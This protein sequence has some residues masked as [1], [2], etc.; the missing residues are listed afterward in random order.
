MA[1]E[2]VT[3]DYATSAGTPDFAMRCNC[4]SSSCRKVITGQDWRRTDL[5]A[6]Y[7]DH[8]VPALLSGIR[9]NARSGRNP[10]DGATGFGAPFNLPL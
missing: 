9:A 8:W 7:G 10:A 5:Q 6:R 4:G 3:N 1:G 2:E